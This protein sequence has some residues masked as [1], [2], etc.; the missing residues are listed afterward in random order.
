MIPIQQRH[1]E[2][3]LEGSVELAADENPNELA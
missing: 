1:F 2:Q 3:T